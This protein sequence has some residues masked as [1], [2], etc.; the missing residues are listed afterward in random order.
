MQKITHGALF[1]GSGGF[2]VFEGIA[3]QINSGDS[4]G[5]N[6]SFNQEKGERSV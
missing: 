4:P 6:E 1:S 5:N 3:L 2:Y